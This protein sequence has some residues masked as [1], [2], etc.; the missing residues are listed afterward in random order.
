MCN[1]CKQLFKEKGII[2]SWNAS[3]THCKNCNVR[4]NLKK[5][6]IVLSE[7]QELVSKFA[8]AAIASAP[9]ISQKYL[10]KKAYRFFNRLTTA[11]LKELS[12]ELKI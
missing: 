5:V 1:K 4:L 12:N 2:E 9:I 7:K 8:N 11:K 6:E 10:Y 3:R